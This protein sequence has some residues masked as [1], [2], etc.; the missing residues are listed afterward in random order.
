MAVL[1]PIDG[2]DWYSLSDLSFLSTTKLPAGSVLYPLSTLT[3]LEDGTSVVVG[4]GDGSAYI[5]DRKKCVERLEHRGTNLPPCGAALTRISGGS[6]IIQSVV[7]GIYNLHTPSTYFPALCK[8]FAPT[9]G[10]QAL[11]AT[12][13]GGLDGRATV[14][15]WVYVEKTGK[16][17]TSLGAIQGIVPAVGP[18]KP[19]LLPSHRNCHRD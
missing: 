5:L 15:I 3:Y 2:V 16:H 13:T 18:H 12:G 19:S 7:C 6:D 14:T 1:N 8:T 10:R 17:G 4:S 9:V 11:I